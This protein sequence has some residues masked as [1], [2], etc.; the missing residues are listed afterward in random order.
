MYLS[1]NKQTHAE[2]NKLIHCAPNPFI[3]L[4]WKLSWEGHGRGRLVLFWL[5][6]PVQFSLWLC[7][8]TGVEKERAGHSGN[9]QAKMVRLTLC[10]F[11]VYMKSRPKYKH[12]G[13]AAVNA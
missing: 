8:S 6:C 13:S 12:T 11:K 4:D 1:C 7:K 2:R 3:P 9:K 10:Q 5:G